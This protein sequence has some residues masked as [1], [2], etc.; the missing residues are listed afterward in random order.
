LIAEAPQN[1]IRLDLIGT[2]SAK[3]GLIEL[4]NRLQLN[5]F[6]T[7]HGWLSQEEVDRKLAEANLG[8]V[9][10][11]ICGHWNHTIPN[12]IFDYMASGLPVLATPVVPIKRIIAETE[13]GL[14]TEDESPESICQALI[15]L[16]DASLRQKLSNNG[17]V[18]I[19]NKYNWERDK[20]VMKSSLSKLGV[21]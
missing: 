2:G 7:I 13:C 6:V 12:K 11:R 20:S 18:A 3:E 16:A 10:Y 19:A 4:C 8:V 5:E 9:T 15:K 1:G 17:R 14:V 21:V